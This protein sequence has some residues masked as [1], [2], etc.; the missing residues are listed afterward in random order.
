MK[1]STGYQ[2]FRLENGIRIVYSYSNSP[3]VHLG[4]FINTGSRDETLKE[5]GMAHFIEHVIF[6]GTAKRKS[7]QIFNCIENV[8]G[9]LN[10]F[11]TKED[12]CI[13]ASFLNEYFERSAELISD[14][15]FNSI[16]PEKELK[17]E[18]E[19]VVD[20]IFYY[21]DIPEETIFEDFEELLFAGH[22]LGRNILGEQN[23]IQK[24][25][26]ADIE[27]F[28]NKNYRT[29]RMVLSVVGDL[30]FGSMIN[31]LKQHFDREMP[32]NKASIK[33]KS[34]NN[35]LPVQK[36]LKKEIFQSHCI[37]G[38]IAYSYND[39]RK[40]GLTLLNNLLG[41]PSSNATLNMSIREKHGLSYNIE[42]NYAPYQDSG[43]FSIYVSSDNEAMEKVM[44][45]IFAELKKLRERKM[46]SL[47]LSR[48][49]LQLAGNLALAFES[50]IAEMLSI[51]KTYL[52]FD[53]VETIAEINRKIE[54]ITADELFEIANEIF[55][56][57]RF[58]Q[59]IYQANGSYKSE[60][61]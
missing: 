10:A 54:K 6:K 38:N 31:I 33:R 46:S 49:K 19:I 5:H 59:L 56:T 43:I 24:F 16:F 3:I 13:H 29:D 4:L 22:P 30:D 35:Y 60:D 50:K 58:T 47:Q 12:T 45:L 25:T 40:L 8:G 1:H 11:T 21:K 36:V 14:V 52:I 23:I 51:G 9:E 61:I 7:Y 15:I 27:S 28:I 39:P 2:Y 17:K 44:S 37:M 55:D 57:N 53:K 20:E 26:K 41:G 42:S 48:A 34:F 32:Y 18:K